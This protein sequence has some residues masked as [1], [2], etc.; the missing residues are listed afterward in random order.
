MPDYAK[1]L[2]PIPNSGF[3][4]NGSGAPLEQGSPFCD[5]ADCGANYCAQCVKNRTFEGHTCEDK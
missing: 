1:Y 4:C 3:I 2:T 5:C